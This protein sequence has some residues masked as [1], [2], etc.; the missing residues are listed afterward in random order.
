[1]GVTNLKTRM[2]LTHLVSIS[3]R[4]M[5]V[6]SVVIKN[7]LQGLESSAKKAQKR[8]PVKLMFDD[9]FERLRGFR[10]CEKKV[11]FLS[12]KSYNNHG[13]LAIKK[14]KSR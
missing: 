5:R 10:D 3:T 2:L 9:K 6:V 8:I 12:S 14:E 7:K 4:C 11:F 13:Q 1:M